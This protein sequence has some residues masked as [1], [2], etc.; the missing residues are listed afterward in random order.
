MYL[1][2]T[3]EQEALRD[4]LVAYYDKLLTPEVQ[5]ALH[6]EHGVGPVTSES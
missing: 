2:Y 1:G 6:L 4:E 3:E 5:E